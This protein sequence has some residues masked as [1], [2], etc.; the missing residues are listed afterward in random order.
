MRR[1][2]PL[3]GLGVALL[4]AGCAPTATPSVTNAPTIRSAATPAPQPLGSSVASTG[5]GNTVVYRGSVPAWLVT[6]GG[7]SR[8]APTYLPYV[9][10]RPPIAGG[11]LF[12]FPLQSGA[13]GSNKIL[14]AMG[15]PR[16]GSDLV[17]S[18]HP[19]TA[20]KPVI[21]ETLLDDSYPGEIYPDGLAVPT[22]G[23]WQLTLSWSG[24][25]ALI[26]LAYT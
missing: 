10:A 17:I 23:C 18:A 21:T 9:I 4:L 24:H 15:L 19:L 3:V 2:P 20:S 22:A 26:E 13:H 1:R 14:W 25:H 16:D 6:A 11:Y 5:C 12:V 8:G 7:G